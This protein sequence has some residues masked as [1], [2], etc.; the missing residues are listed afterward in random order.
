[1]KAQTKNHIK[2]A[3][4]FTI[5]LFAESAADLGNYLVNL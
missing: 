3:L 4:A 5:L 1:M 2:M